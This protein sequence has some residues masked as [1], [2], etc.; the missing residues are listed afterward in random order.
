MVN[1]FFIY[2]DKCFH[3]FQEIC[4]KKIKSNIV[5]VLQMHTADLQYVVEYTC[6]YDI[7]TEAG[8]FERRNGV[9]HKSKSQMFILTK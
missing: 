4:S 5:Y 9:F 7:N 3:S 6:G 1:V 8:L 2:L